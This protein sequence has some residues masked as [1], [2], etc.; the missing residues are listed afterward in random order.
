MGEIRIVAV[1]GATGRQGRGVVDA[2][3]FNK[4]NIEYQVRPLTRSCTSKLAQNFERDYPSLKLTKWDP[5]DR[6]TLE[7]CFEGCYGAFVDSGILYEPGMEL[8]D[9]LSAELQLG[10]LIRQAAEHAN[11]NHIVYPTFPSVSKASNNSIQIRHFEIKHQI[12]LQLRASKVPS[13][14][15]CPGPFY[16]DFHD[17]GYA[18]FDSA[19]GV[20]IF[21]TPAAPEKRMGWSDPGHDIGW[22]TRAV[23]DAGHGKLKDLENVPVCGQSLTYEELASKFSAVTGVKAEYRQCS[24]DEFGEREGARG[25][26]GK[27]MEARQLGKWLA[28]APDGKTCYGTIDMDVLEVVE[29]TL[30]IKAQSWEMFL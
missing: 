7:K 6:S 3:T 11:L 8:D 2:L 25:V 22:F 4:G 9:W 10:D 15:L 24:V 23:L 27:G 26:G 5:L 29:R 19:A 28:V 1:M 21:S 16:T 20:V 14:M 13:T 30:N 18:S 12:G 17:M